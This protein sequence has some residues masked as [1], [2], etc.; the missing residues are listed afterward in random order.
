MNPFKR[1]FITLNGSL[2]QFANQLENHEAIAE[3]AI[4]SVEDSARQAAVQH[5]LLC[6][7]LDRM[8]KQL[9]NLQQTREKWTERAK[10]CGPTHPDDALEC[11]RRLG[12]VEEEFKELTQRKS[13]QEKL[14]KELATNLRFVEEKIGALKAQKSILVTKEA[15]SEISRTVADLE[16]GSLR[17]MENIFDRWESRIARNTAGGVC[18]N[19]DNFE[20]K[21]EQEEQAAALKARLKEITG[22]E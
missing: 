17:R 20:R 18:A 6:R 4:R 14:E 8:E 11:V 10:K 16:G 2:D 13:E 22:K 7:D 3:S 12:M 21:F 15:Q 19:T 5:K 1:I 9:L